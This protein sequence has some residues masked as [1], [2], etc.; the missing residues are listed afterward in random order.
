MKKTITS[1]V[2]TAVMALGINV[3]QAASLEDSQVK[4]LN[5]KAAAK[6]TYYN[7][8]ISLN[9]TYVGSSTQAVVNVGS[10]TLTTLVPG[11]VGTTDLS[12]N[13]ANTAYDTMGELCDAIDADDDYE[14]SLVDSKRDDS[15]ILT[16]NVTGTNTQ[17]AKAA[18]GFNVL[19]DS[20]CVELA[21]GTQFELRLGITP[22]EGKAVVLKYCT[23]N[24]SITSTEQLKVWG[25]LAKYAGV[26]DGVTRNDTT[27]VF[28]VPLAEDT[29]KTIGN[30]YNM[31]FLEF[32]KD[33]HVVIGTHDNDTA[34]V[35]DT[36]SLVCFW[37]EK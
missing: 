16:Q 6:V 7:D 26:S 31:N 24:A 11:P 19:I 35:A 14:C 25:K 5:K 17:N 28:S 12:Y 10:G 1:I 29:D 33:E 30:I 15:S 21:S 27:E 32:A 9:I 3:A 34:Q 13:L 18:G 36:N 20:G 2:L 23:G 37:D 4:E 22:R 8:A